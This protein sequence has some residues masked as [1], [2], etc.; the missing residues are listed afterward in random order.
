[1]KAP[2]TAK[3]PSSPRLSPPPLRRLRRLGRRRPSRR[4]S[5]RRRRLSRRLSPPWRRRPSTASRRALQSRG[6]VFVRALCA[7]G[8]EL[9]PTA[10]RR[11]AAIRSCSAAAT[12]AAV[13]RVRAGAPLADFKPPDPR[14]LR[15]RLRRGGRR[16]RPREETRRPPPNRAR[17]RLGAGSHLLG[18]RVE[19]FFAARSGQP[20]RCL[21]DAA[22]RAPRRGAALFLQGGDE[23]RLARVQLLRV[24]VSVVL[25]AAPARASAV[26]RAASTESFASRTK[27]LQTLRLERRRSCAS[28]RHEIGELRHLVGLERG[29]APVEIRG[30][31]PRCPSSGSSSRQRPRSAAL[32]PCSSACLARARATRRRR[33]CP[34][35][36]ILPG[37]SG[38]T[39]REGGAGAGR[40][41]SGAPGASRRANQLVF[42]PR[43][44]P[45]RFAL[46]RPER[47][48]A[49][50]VFSAM[51]VSSRGNESAHRR[52]PMGGP[53]GRCARASTRGGGEVDGRS[54]PGP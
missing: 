36:G 7:R 37:T 21:L 8:E 52:G 2:A 5:R 18:R 22:S 34:P 6:D 17:E 12:G 48:P 24:A 10:P 23:P 25:S 41:F 1:M 14:F 27:R 19:I 9:Y 30:F 35:L 15:R 33:R 20:R 28:L 43:E 4:R 49:R 11:A 53:G 31:F 13:V 16:R 46:E 40:S 42:I 3:A 50:M 45:R 26:S 51:R 47:C 32:G 54:I 29:E 39:L 44:I 38:G